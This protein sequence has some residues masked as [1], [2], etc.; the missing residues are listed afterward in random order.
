M[1]E[2]HKNKLIDK[3]V[4]TLL[5]TN[6]SFNFFVDWN[7]LI[8]IEKYD[9][10]LN[11]LN[12]LIR[13]K[14]FKER[15]IE[16]L[17]KVPSVIAT[18]PLL[19]ALSR[20]ER[21]VLEKGKSKLKILNLAKS[22]YY[23]YSFIEYKS[24]SFLSSDEKE[25]YY[26][27]FKDMGLENLFTNLLEK[28]IKDYVSGVLVGLDSNGRKN[29]SG[30]AFEDICQPLIAEIC[31]K[32]DITLLQ[33]KKLGEL[34]NFG[35]PINDDFRNRK[36]D[37]ILIKNRKA[38]NIEVNYFFA[39]GSKPEEIIDSYI[40][41]NNELNLRGIK[42]LLITDGLCW[43]NNSKNQLEKAF[44]YITLMN[45][46]MSNDGYLETIIKDVFLLNN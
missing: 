7:N 5:E 29:R 11:A 22:F 39:G 30:R 1:S 36:A 42:F 14:N 40:N 33:Q 27:L 17:T 37:F 45:Y 38:L 23:K 28:S 44:K 25:L 9:V 43:D 6:R 20:N 32:Y 2:N 18:F 12:S 4:N 34:A 3:F 21:K 24:N 35:I 8:E 15:F 41:R 31:K 46:N 10:E 16:L 26:A 19:F 13:V